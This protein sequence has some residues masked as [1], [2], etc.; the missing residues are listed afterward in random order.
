MP[1]CFILSPYTR[2]ILCDKR[3]KRGGTLNVL[4]SFPLCFVVNLKNTSEQVL[5]VNV[6]ELFE[7]SYELSIK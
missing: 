7:E 2:V 5:E 3:A 1:L 6:N 4:Y